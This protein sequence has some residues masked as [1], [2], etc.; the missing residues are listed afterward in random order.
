MRCRDVE[1]LSVGYL[2]GRLDPESAGT[3]EAH[4]ESCAACRET[5]NGMRN[6]WTRLGDLPLS[7]PDARLRG[8]F[9]AA[10]TGE[11]RKAGAAGRPGS[12]SPYAERPF[13]R[14]VPAFGLPLALVVLGFI[15]GFS[16][17]GALRADGE[18]AGLRAEVADMKRMLTLS[19][20]N[21]PASAD[22][23]RGV[24][25]GREVAGPDAS[26]Q[27]ALLD[28]LNGDPSVGVRLAAV[29]ALYR[30]GDRPSVRAE[31]IRSLGL[32]TSPIVQI[33]II[34]LLVDIRE[35]K[36][37]DALR[38]LIHSGFTNPS[39]KQHAEWGIRQLT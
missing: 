24:Q 8:R 29:D 9:E 4:L 12:A 16:V 27:Q 15:A 10:L 35:R 18:N 30:V 13:G 5:V 2:S 39:V 37:L 21:Q 31:L 17:R 14:F 33:Q 1:R 34:D 22:R 3:L 38:F 6:V 23:L 19:L 11:K 28:A 32:Q 36:A 25:V 7:E 26:V 20:L